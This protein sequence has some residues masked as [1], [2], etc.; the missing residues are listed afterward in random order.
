LHLAN[1][2]GQK[3]VEDEKEA[4]LKL[5]QNGGLYR[6][7]EKGPSSCAMNFGGKRKMFTGD[8][9]HCFQE[10]LER[11]GEE[12]EL[13]WAVC[14]EGDREKIYKRGRRGLSDSLLQGSG[15][16]KRKEVNEKTAG[17]T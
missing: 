3:A 15:T 8:L 6:E 11:K 14:Q 9:S 12:Q 1:K 16:E 2:L 4:S 13:K 7:G 5:R 17:S 10:E